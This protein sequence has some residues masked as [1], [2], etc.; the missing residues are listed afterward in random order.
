MSVIH[1]PLISS[2]VHFLSLSN[3]LHFA[4]QYGQLFDSPEG[5]DLRFK[6]LSGVEIQVITHSLHPR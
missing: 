1:N 6:V 3:S 2:P 4:R 5:T